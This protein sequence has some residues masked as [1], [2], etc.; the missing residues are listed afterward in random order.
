[1]NR[2]V[3]RESIPLISVGTTA[4]EGE[5]HA[6][7]RNLEMKMTSFTQLNSAYMNLSQRN[8][9]ETSMRAFCRRNSITNNHLQANQTAVDL[10][11][12]FNANLGPL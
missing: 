1:M 4:I 9:N 3:K 6:D 7:S 2:L 10:K 11:R 8:L 12:L 5:T